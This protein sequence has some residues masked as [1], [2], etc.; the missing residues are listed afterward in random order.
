METQR[1]TFRKRGVKIERNVTQ[2]ECY[3][4][5]TVWRDRQAQALIKS[6]LDY[7]RIISHLLSLYE[8]YKHA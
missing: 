7:D 8:A 4:K 5:I 3:D 1:M 2:N 6:Y